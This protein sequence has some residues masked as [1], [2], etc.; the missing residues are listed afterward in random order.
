MNASQASFFADPARDSERAIRLCQVIYRPRE[1]AR[2]YA[3]LACN[4]YNGCSHRCV[5]C[6]GPSVLHKTAEQ[7]FQPSTRENFL[8]R[9][10]RDCARLQRA[11]VHGRVLLSFTSDPYQPLDVK[12]KVTRSAISLLK[13]HGLAVQ[14]L[15]KGGTR[16]LRDIGLFDRRDAFA[17]TLTFLDDGDSR[18]WEPNAALPG[19]RIEA[20]KA[21]HERGIPTWVSLEPVIDPA[22]S[23]EIIGQTHPS[24]DL[25][26]VGKLN[27]HPLAQEINWEL[28]A[29]YA[30]MLLKELGY[31]R[32]G[33]DGALL[34]GDR[35]FYIKQD[36][37]A[38]L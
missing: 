36:L 37:A 13:G 3:P 17:T 29:T 9:L 18:K 10:V 6:L 31:R 16:A 15:T 11:G 19:D 20:I 5:Y 7:F 12:E 4:V 1:S 25:F 34:P 27:Y 28:F 21:F 38:Y 30:V 24:V 35:G 8:L 32:I 22:Q 33:A 26:Q 2:E 14:A 23:L